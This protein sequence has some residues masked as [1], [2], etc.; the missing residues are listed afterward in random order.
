MYLVIDKKIGKY[1]VFVN[2]KD[3]YGIYEIYEIYETPDSYIIITL[4]LMNLLIC[5]K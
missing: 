2:A 5:L 1:D 3:L 4:V